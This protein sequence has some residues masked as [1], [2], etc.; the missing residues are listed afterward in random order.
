MLNYS[1]TEIIDG[2]LAEFERLA[3]IPRPSGHEKAV[4]DYLLNT[5]K[6]M[7]CVVRQDE[8]NNIIADL[9]ATPGYELAPVI[10]MQS[11]MDMV[12]VADHGVEY[13]PLTDSIKLIRDD[14]ILTADGTSLGADDGIG[15][16]EIIFIMKNLKEH[17]LL[18]A[19]ITVDEERGMTG[20]INLDK[21]YLAD[22]SYMINC[23]S[24]NYDEL[25]VGSAGSV[26]VD[27]NRQLTFTKPQGTRGYKLHIKGLKG[28]HSG[29][30]IH[31]GRANAIRSMALVLNALDEAGI[32]YELASFNGGKARNSI[33]AVAEAIITAVVDKENIAEIIEMEKEKYLDIYGEV[34]GGISYEIDE[35]DLPDRVMTAEEQSSIIKLIILLHSGVYSMSQLNPSLVET[36]ANLGMVSMENDNVIN[37]KILPRSSVDSKVELLALQAD[38][39]AELTGF[40]ALIDAKTPGWKERRESRL[41]KIM[42]E[43]F[44][45][46]NN[47]PMKVES[48]HAG[49]ECG[50]HLEK[51]PQLDIVSIGVTTHDIHSPAEWLEISTIVPQVKLICETIKRLSKN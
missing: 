2:V 46:Q 23:D 39:L 10:A 28:G 43:V 29:M 19:I 27:F 14:N 47:K 26:N 31:K 1:N 12:C 8:V 3:E 42:Q 41:A 40:T 20:A 7:G 18:R 48:I 32:N 13:D 4:S 36:S 49:L 37:I 35:V 11:H 21:K 22:V 34:D 16:A 45:E 38:I 24:E 50:W 25:T 33:P 30:E 5:F 15:I 6:E 51:N 9:P 44:Q 17:G